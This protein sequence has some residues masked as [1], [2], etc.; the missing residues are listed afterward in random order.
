MGERL[1]NRG[2]AHVP[3]DLVPVARPAQTARD[4]PAG[5]AGLLAHRA[6]H[7]RKAVVVVGEELIDTRRQRGETPLVSGEDLLDVEVANGAQR[8]EVIGQWVG[9]L[10][11]VHGD[12]GTDARQHVVAAQQQAAAAI[13]EADVT[14]RMAGGVQRHDV[15]AAQVDA[16]TVLEKHV[17][18]AWLTNSRRPIDASLS[19]A[20][21][22]PGTPQSLSRAR[23]CATRVS[24][25]AP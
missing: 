19:S 20:V 14:R 7:D 21:T 16:A 5:D 10:L 25:P 18:S 8:R 24:M 17:R 13:E 1:T 6:L 15:P 2:T 22:A 11:S 23:I 9:G 4:L 3:V 12:V